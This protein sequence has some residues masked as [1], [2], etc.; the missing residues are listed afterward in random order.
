MT[1]TEPRAELATKDAVPLDQ[2]PFTYQTL[3]TIA[4]TEFVPRAIRGNAPAVLAAVLT[5]REMGLPP[6]EA[7]RC[8]DMIDGTPSPSAELLLRLIREH[9]H[10]VVL[11]EQTAERC[12]VVGMRKG[13]PADL[14]HPFHMTVTADIGEYK[15]LANKN[16]WKNYPKAMLFW[17]CITMLARQHFADAVGA[18]RVSYTG[19][20]LGGDFEDVPPPEV[21]VDVERIDDEPQTVY[22]VDRGE[23]IADATAL[24]GP[25]VDDSKTMPEIET[26]VR[27]LYR[28]MEQTGEWLGA[29]DDDQLHVDL[30]A[31]GVA[32]VSDLRKAELVEFAQEA[33]NKARQTLAELPFDEDDE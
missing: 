29:G 30:A 9:G 8:I 16:N 27:L 15:H 23:A 31:K 2:A 10:R 6:M 32:H 19:E 17:R 13:D 20:E 26:F 33:V 25:D 3:R 1:T 22:D 28:R 21:P 7:I 14:E 24:V 12:K 11:I 4:N 18:A 5:G